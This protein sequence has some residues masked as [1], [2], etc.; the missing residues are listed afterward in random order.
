MPSVRRKNQNIKVFFVDFTRTMHRLQMP[1][2]VDNWNLKCLTLDMAMVFTLT[3]NAWMWKH[4]VKGEMAKLYSRLGK[5]CFPAKKA[6]FLV[7]CRHSVMKILARPFLP[8]PHPLQI[9]F[10]LVDYR[11][12]TVKSERCLSNLWSYFLNF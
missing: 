9:S 3:M 5:I 11:L 1:C 8:F 4:F 10:Y 2:W 12:Q 7:K 6:I